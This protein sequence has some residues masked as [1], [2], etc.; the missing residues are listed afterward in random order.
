MFKAGIGTA[1]EKPRYKRIIVGQIIVICPFGKL[2]RHS[3][4]AVTVVE[5]AFARH[6]FEIL[7]KCAI[8]F[9]TRSIRSCPGFK[10][11]AGGYLL[12][13][14]L[15]IFRIDITIGTIKRKTIGGESHQ[16]HFGLAFGQSA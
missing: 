11:I 2:G 5:V 4:A 9:A 8:V 10:A 1:F 6:P 3:E 14:F 16:N 12:Q 13:A 15:W 7:Q